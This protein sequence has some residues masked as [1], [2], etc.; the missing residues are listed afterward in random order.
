[1]NEEQTK[2]QFLKQKLV[3]MARW[4]TGVV[5]EENLPADMIAG[6]TE[7]TQLEATVFANTLH[8]NSHQVTAKNWEALEDLAAK[9][10]PEILEVVALIRKREEMHEKFWRYMDLFVDVAAA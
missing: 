8:E 3:N 5:G 6:I 10:S 9:S 4:V 7:R 2:G 1:M